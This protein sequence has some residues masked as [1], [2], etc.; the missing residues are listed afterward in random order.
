MTQE[1][2]ISPFVPIGQVFQF[3]VYV[4]DSITST[5]GGFVVQQVVRLVVRLA[6]CCMQ[7]AGDLLWT[8][9]AI[10]CTTCCRPKT[11]CLFY[12][13]LWTLVLDLLLAFEL[14]SICRTACC[15][16][17]TTNRSYGVRH[18]THLFPSVKISILSTHAF[19]HGR[20]CIMRV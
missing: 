7:L 5:S 3:C 6:D 4:S 16:T 14:L 9:C 20:E 2:A 11:C 19:R 17:S 13:S 8:C 1:N 15:T 12:N 10:S 18:Y